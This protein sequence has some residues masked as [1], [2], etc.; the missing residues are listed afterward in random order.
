MTLLFVVAPKTTFCEH[1]YLLVRVPG[2]AVCPRCLPPGS[3]RMTRS[4]GRNGVNMRAWIARTWTPEEDEKLKRMLKAG[5]SYTL[6]AQVLERG[7]HA[8]QER[9]SSLGLAR[10]R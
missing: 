6:I 9:A 4:S 8:V 3:P 1:G 7:R 10:R 2:H 5:K